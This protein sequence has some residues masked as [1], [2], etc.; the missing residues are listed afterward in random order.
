MTSENL[1][2]HNVSLKPLAGLYK[3]CYNALVLKIKQGEGVLNS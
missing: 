2:K 1:L 3:I